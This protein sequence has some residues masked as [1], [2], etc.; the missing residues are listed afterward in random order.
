MSEGDNALSPFTLN[1]FLGEG[2]CRETAAQKKERKEMYSRYIHKNTKINK[3]KEMDH[4]SQ[5]IAFFE[6]EQPTAEYPQEKLDEMARSSK[7]IKDYKMQRYGE[8]TTPLSQ[9]YFYPTTQPK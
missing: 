1:R 6:N 4:L 9:S 7:M 2:V 3:D 8:N 5:D